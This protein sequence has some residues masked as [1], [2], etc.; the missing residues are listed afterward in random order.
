MPLVAVG[1]RTGTIWRTMGKFTKSLATR[2]RPTRNTN[3]STT[4]EMRLRF[5]QCPRR[6][7]TT[8]GEEEAGD[9]EAGAAGE[10]DG[11]EV[12]AGLEAAGDSEAA[13]VSGEEE[14]ALT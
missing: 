11:L 3:Q 10:R 6:R 9:S 2:M 8:F 14:E 13:V 12:E 1:R 7:H 4:E 5:R